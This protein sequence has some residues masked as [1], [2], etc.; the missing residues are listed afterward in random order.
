ML[1]EPKKTKNTLGQNLCT[2]DKSSA[3]ISLNLLNNVPKE[4]GDNAGAMNWL[5]TTSLS[6]QN[7]LLLYCELYL[8]LQS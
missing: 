1:E 5:H 2:H 7:P 6:R 4:R 8:T 3:C